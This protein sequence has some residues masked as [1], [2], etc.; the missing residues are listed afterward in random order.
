LDTKRDFQ[1]AEDFNTLLNNDT[2]VQDPNNAGAKNVW[3]IPWII[4]AKKGFPNF[5]EFSIENTIDVTRRLRFLK[6]SAHHVTETNQSFIFRLN[7]QLGIELWNSYT[8]AY[9]RELNIGVYDDVTITIKNS[10]NATLWPVKRVTSS[11]PI[12]LPAYSFSGTSGRTNGI[13]G[14]EPGTFQSDPTPNPNSFYI[15][16][17]LSS[18]T[19]PP[20]FYEF[21]PPGL[22]DASFGLRWDSF[23]P[24]VLPAIFLQTTNHLRVYMVDGPPGNAHVIDYVQFAGPVESTNIVATFQGPNA[25]ATTQ[26]PNIQAPY[27]DMWSTSTTKTGV[28]TGV[29]HQISVSLAAPTNGWSQANQ[30]AADKFAVFMSGDVG[31]APYPNF[32]TDPSLQAE[33]DKEATNLVAQAPYSPTVT[34][35]DYMSWQAND[36]LV[37]YFAGD[38]P[39]YGTEQPSG[40]MTGVNA[41]SK[42]LTSAIALPNIGVLNDRYGPWG[43]PSAVSDGNPQGNGVRNSVNPTVQDPLVWSSDF[44][45]FPT[46]KFPSVGWLGRVHR[47]T[48][49]QTVYLKS[50]DVRTQ[51]T[52]GLNTWQYWTSDLIPF[53]A[54][55]S[56]PTA[57]RLLFD[58]FT[59]EPNDNASRGL[60]SV[61]QKGLAAWSALFGGMVALTNVNT[62]INTLEFS[63]ALFNYGWTNINP[64]GIN[65]ANSALARLVTSPLGINATRANTNLF[66]NGSFQHVGEILATP[67]LTDQNPFF[68]TNSGTGAT[69][70]LTNG[71]TDAMYEWLPEQALPLLKLDSSPRY[72]IYCYGQALK[73]V[74]GAQVTSGVNFGL[75]TNYQVVAESA[76]KAVVQVHANIVIQNGRSVTNYTTTV[77]SY[78]ALPPDYV[79]P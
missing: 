42:M 38:L 31:S 24:Q 12:N 33:L 36:P 76:A 7:T 16:L 45:A 62:S 2:Y 18:N 1:L 9:P 22:L 56:S 55:A 41:D 28:P 63:G 67:A 13:V 4:G 71:L 32:Q 19:I 11:Y 27:N 60:L 10:N 47:G 68:N 54:A 70:F 20:V 5:N 49:W 43:R 40:L 64:A 78:N 6:S 44:W 35:R 52:F 17:F 15:P 8:N 69:P 57:D 61:N 26:A 74:Q 48:P 53:D 39:F 14:F 30:T 79:S 58:L 34:I 77:E 51:T 23:P 25:V 65:A 50:R 29:D 21:S 3:G 75:T 59:A 73:P 37:H 46:N 72:V 66:P